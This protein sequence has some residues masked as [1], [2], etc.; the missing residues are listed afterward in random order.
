MADPRTY[1]T[2]DD[3]RQTGVYS[4]RCTANGKVYVG[5]AAASFKKR[6]D[7]HVRDLRNNRHH[8]RRLQRAWNKYGEP[9]FLFEIVERTEPEHAVAQEHVFINY[10]K[11]ADKNHGFNSSPTAGSPLG[12]KH[13]LETR[14]KVAAAGRGRKHSAE[15]LKKIG[16]G[17]RGKVI[18]PEMR[19]KI[20]AT[21]LGRKASPETRAKLS[22]AHCAR[23]CDPDVRANHAKALR[24]R[25]RPPEVIKQIRLTKLRKTA[26]M[27]ETMDFYQRRRF[28]YASKQKTPH[29][30]IA[31]LTQGDLN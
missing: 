10:W 14:A 29:Q 18:S 22:A 23:F 7:E 20:A 6:W 31:E 12:V 30:V 15:S 25:K 26:A 19:A 3:D 21:L 1:R 11:A 24:G 4:I 17:N 28:M 2:L 9:S 5:S 8:A 16:D 27:W 13:S